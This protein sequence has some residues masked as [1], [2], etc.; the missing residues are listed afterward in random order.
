LSLGQKLPTLMG[1]SCC[2]ADCLLSQL[3]A[4]PGILKG[5]YQVLVNPM[6][7]M[8]LPL[9]MW[10]CPVDVALPPR[11]RKWLP[12]AARPGQRAGELRLP[13]SLR[14]LT[15]ENSPGSARL[16]CWFQQHKQHSEDLRQV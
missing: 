5:S 11:K 6:Q 4:C 12:S 14:R 1:S 3:V 9:N 2:M 13:G 10:S 15:P 8:K 7:K 16:R